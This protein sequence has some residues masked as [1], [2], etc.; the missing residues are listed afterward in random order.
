[1][2]K[3]LMLLGLTF[4]F[5]AT[6]LGCSSNTT[7]TKSDSPVPTSS[8]AGTENP[9]LT[10]QPAVNT[11]S[12]IPTPPKYTGLPE[13]YFM[14]EI[15]R[16][17]VQDVKAN[18]DAGSNILIVDVRYQEYYEVSRIPGAISMPEV[19]MKGPYTILDNY[20]EIYTYCT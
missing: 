16:I 8:P 19:G 3:P 5:L 20:D 11:A 2:K 9:V 18:L 15:P 14:P 13:N 6:T 4:L 12:P 17:S 10:S 7:H 1:M